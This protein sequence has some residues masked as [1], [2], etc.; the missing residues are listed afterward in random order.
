MTPR[1]KLVAGLVV[2]ALGAGCAT[3]PEPALAPQHP[4]NVVAAESAVAPLS[5]TLAIATA[6]PIPAQELDR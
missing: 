6:D 5:S 4:A 3:A 1:T 2:A